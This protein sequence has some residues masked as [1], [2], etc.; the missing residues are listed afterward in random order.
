MSESSGIHPGVN[1]DETTEKERLEA[2][3]TIFGF[4]I[5]LM[6]DMVLFGILFATYAAMSEN[7]TASGP[8][9]ITLFELRP[10]F[11]QTLLLLTSSFTFGLAAVVLKYHQDPRGLITF[12]SMTFLLGAAFVFFEA[13][14]F[15][16][17]I[18]E[19][20]APPQRSGFLS[21]FYL[22]TGT[23]MI[24]VLSGMIW[25]A[26]LVVQLLLFGLVHEVRLRLLRLA[27][28]WH[29]LDVVWIGIFT[30]VFLYGYVK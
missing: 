15:H 13:K 25:M 9:P 12:L 21:S 14:D 3:E 22:L 8:T 1:L 7:G 4:W 27:L 17:F 28:F 23:H 24:H 18:T 11:I 5:F 29:M 20:N 6:S 2:E 10:V 30:F 26:V 16:H 19:K